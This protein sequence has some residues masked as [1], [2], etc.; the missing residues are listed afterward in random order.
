M[1]PTTWA[2]ALL[3]ISCSAVAQLLLKIGMTNLG[4]PNLPAGRSLLAAATNGYVGVGFAFYAL[5]AIL[6]L[7][8]LSRVELS[9]A[10]PLVSLAFVL[11]AVLSWLVLEERLSAVRVA[12]ITLIVIGVVVMG[13]K[14]A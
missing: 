14:S 3:S 2:V 9:L 11:V 12:G 8:V 5:G 7:K 6:W 1:T 10:Y 4:P 13:L